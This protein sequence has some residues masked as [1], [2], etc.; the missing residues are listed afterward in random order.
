MGRGVCIGAM[1]IATGRAVRLLPH[2]KV[3][4]LP[5]TRYAVGEIWEVAATLRG[6]IDPPHFEDHDEGEARLIGPCRD[7]AKGVLERVRPWEG[8]PEVLFDGVLRWR[9]TGSGF[10]TRDRMPTCSVGFWRP[11]R[12]LVREFFEGHDHYSM[13]GKGRRFRIPLV[14]TLEPVPVLPARTLLRVSLARWWV[15]PQA[16]HEGETCSL[17]LSGWIGAVPD[18]SS[19]GMPRLEDLPF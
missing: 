7:L 18:T 9:K 13:I 19:P 6:D 10:V 16:P 4:H 5:Q 2:G 12:P 15:N 8:E 14:G 1:D 3:Y 11:P 17:Q